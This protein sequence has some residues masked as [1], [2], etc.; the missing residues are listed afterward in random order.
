MKY[1]FIIVACIAWAAVVTHY[2][3]Y[4]G[5]SFL[6]GLFIGAVVAWITG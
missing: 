2:N 6:G 5:V 1:L 4:W 3:L